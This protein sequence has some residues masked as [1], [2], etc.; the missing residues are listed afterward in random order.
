MLI[1]NRSLQVGY[2]PQS[3]KSSHVI[4]VFKSG[5]RSNIENY[6]PISILPA[7]SKVFECLVRDTLFNFLKMRI[8][9]EQHGFFP[10]RSTASN[11]VEFVDFTINSFEDGLQV[12]VVFTDFKKAFDRISHQILLSKLYSIGVHS[13]LLLWVRSYLADRNQMVKKG[14]CV[15]NSYDVPSG[16]PQGKG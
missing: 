6:R 5:D 11:L 14:N 10:G 13:S 9:P 15:S 1:F 3:W 16:V 2:F 8:I 4:P 7:V 12:D